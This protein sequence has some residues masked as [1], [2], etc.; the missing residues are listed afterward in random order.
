MAAS[1]S[2]KIRRRKSGLK[3][4]PKR[5]LTAQLP[6][7]LRIP[8]AIDRGAFYARPEVALESEEQ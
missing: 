1:K 6:V 2:S 4:A 3:H 5:T 7:N 8:A